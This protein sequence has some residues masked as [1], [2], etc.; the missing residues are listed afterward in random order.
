[1]DDTPSLIP[2]G[3]RVLGAD[4][5]SVLLDEMTEIVSSSR[6]FKSL[7][8]AGRQR[9]LTSGYIASFA[10]GETILRQGDTGTTMFLVLNGRVRVEASTPG[11]NVV[12][13]E[14]GRDAC[15]GEVSVLTGGE[16][17]ATVTALTDV[18]AVAFEKHRIERILADYPKVRALLE[19]LVE[20]RARDAI[21][22]I[23]GST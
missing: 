5:R 11:G 3:G 21:E 15:I 23:V 10:A 19:A 8:E 16:R 1:M 7:D 17:T 9:V 6:L 4:E 18:D 12:L 2:P 14:L 13:A 22:K 20:G